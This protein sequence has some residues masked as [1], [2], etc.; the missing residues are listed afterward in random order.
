MTKTQTTTAPGPPVYFLWA[1]SARQA[2]DLGAGH[3]EL[4]P[5]E[6]WAKATG[7]TDGRRIRQTRFAV[8]P[9]EGKTIRFTDD[10]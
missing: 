7:L 4:K 2:K 1:T 3:L 5:D 10:S 6:V 8:R 9:L